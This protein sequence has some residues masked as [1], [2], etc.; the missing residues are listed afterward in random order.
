MWLATLKLSPIQDTKKEIVAIHA[1][2][3]SKN[4]I[5]QG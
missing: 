1:D 3:V 5:E 2:E 4:V